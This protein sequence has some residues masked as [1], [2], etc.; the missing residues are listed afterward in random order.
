MTAPGRLIPAPPATR[1][2][3]RLNRIAASGGGHVDRV[4]RLVFIVL[5]A[6]AGT[7]GGG[8]LLL[9]GGLLHWTSPGTLYARRA[10]DVAHNRDLVAV[11][12]MALCVALFV[13]GLRW[14]FAQ[15]RPVSDG[16]RLG[17][18]RLVTG[19]QGRTTVAATT[20]AK[21]AAAD[22][23]SRPG[24]TSAKVRLR[25]LD[26]RTRV[27][28]SVEVSLEAD[29]EAVLDELEGA[30]YNLLAALDREPADADTEIRLRFARP[31]RS[32]RPAR[33]L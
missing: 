6:V 18:L 4:N 33:V 30:L 26:P 17:T 1:A 8:G 5:G 22:L 29:P 24:I 15:L 21:A 16:E 19:P 11:I 7:A 31:G 10:A 12:A 13:V 28:L 27:T 3:R 14:A 9:G 20:V 25:A 32:E 23:S 2:G